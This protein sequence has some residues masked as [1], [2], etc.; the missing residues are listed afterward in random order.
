[1]I[2]EDLR[3]SSFSNVFTKKQ[4]LPDSPEHRLLTNMLFMKAFPTWDSAF[5]PTKIC[6]L[7]LEEAT[8]YSRT[9]RFE[10][11]LEKILIDGANLMIY[12]EIGSPDALTSGKDLDA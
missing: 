10:T 4:K 11:D 2:K 6:M 5:V 12:S 8:K 1:M 7:L 3:S 9:R